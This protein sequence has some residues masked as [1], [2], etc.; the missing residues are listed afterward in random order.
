M[1]NLIFTLT[2]IFVIIYLSIIYGSTALALSG[3][4]VA[5]FAV[6]SY[7]Y[8]IFAWFRASCKIEAP[9]AVTEPGRDVGVK[10]YGGTSGLFYAGKIRYCIKI[11]ND[12]GKGKKR[13]RLRE[14][15]IYNMSFPEAGQ[16]HVAIN[17][18]KI[19]EPAGVLCIRK[20]MNESCKIIVLPDIVPVHAELSEGTKNFFGDADV[21]DDVRPGHD[22]SERFGVRPFADGDKIQ[23]I[24]WKLS[25]KSDALMVKENSLPKAC[26]AVILAELCADDMPGYIKVIASYSFSLMDIRCPHYVAW[27][28]GIK[29]DIIRI[30]VDDEES[31]YI[32]LNYLLSEKKAKRASGIEDIYNE[33]YR[34]ENILHR[35]FLDSRMA[36]YRNGERIAIYGKGTISKQLEHTEI[37]L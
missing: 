13:L 35:L 19:Y 23:S 11:N 26:S 18:I 14:A 3:L 5:A 17:K 8:L 28:S 36:M 27:F 15:G 7:V 12:M 9:V 16:F 37:L 10:V 21:Y 2:V 31:F 24:H 34:S 1:I 4:A 25:A 32:M 20:K 30:R 29:D 6:L 33:R 22:P